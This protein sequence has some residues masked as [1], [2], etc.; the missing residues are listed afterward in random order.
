MKTMI[1]MAIARKSPGLV[2][3]NE[4][5]INRLTQ[6]IEDRKPKEYNEMN[7]DISDVMYLNNSERQQLHEAKQST[8]KTSASDAKARNAER[9]A[10][11]NERKKGESKI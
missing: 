1:T 7:G 11:R 8:A 10:K 9:I 2:E 6:L 4:Q 3:T 5:T